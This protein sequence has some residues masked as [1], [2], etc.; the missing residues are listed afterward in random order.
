VKS[1]LYY[2]YFNAKVGRED[3]VK[4]KIGNENLFKI[5][6]NGVRVVHFATSKNITLKCTLFAHRNIHPHT[7]IPFDE[8]IHIHINHVFIHKS[9]HSNMV[10]I[11]LLEDLTVTLTIM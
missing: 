2:F 10:D 7:W 11:H 3:I 5:N 6:N 4:P 8:K 9:W 1:N